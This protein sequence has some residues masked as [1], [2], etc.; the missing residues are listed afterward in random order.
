MFYINQFGTAIN[1]IHV[2]TCTFSNFT[3]AQSNNDRGF[4][5]INFPM[6]RCK[7]IKKIRDE[8]YNIPQ[9]HNSWGMECYAMFKIVWESFSK[10]ENKKIGSQKKTPSNFDGHESQLLLL[11]L[12][13]YV[14]YLRYHFFRWSTI[15]VYL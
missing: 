7:G 1:P 12:V 3:G 14:Y 10:N 11:W 5:S 2:N 6:T 13:L 9:N 8:Y 15:R 4:Q